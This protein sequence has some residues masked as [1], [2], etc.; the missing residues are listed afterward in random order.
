[1]DAKLAVITGADGGMGRIITTAVAKAG[2]QVIM[3][4]RN[5]ES[6]RQICEQI[7][8]D[9]HN[10]QIEVRG[11][12]LASL[13]SVST[14]AQTLLQEKRTLSLFINNAGVLTTSNRRSE[15]G[16]ETI[17][18][19]N[20]VAP[21]LLTRLLLP[22]MESGSR[23][24][25]TV[26]CTYM[27]GRIQDHFFEKGKDGRFNRISVYSN[28]KLALLLFTRE[29]AQ[30]VKEKGITV[31]ASD[32]GIVDTNMIRMDAWFDPLTDYLFRPFIKT[33]AQ[34][35]ATA[36]HLAL[37]EEARGKSACC[38]ANSKERK[39]SKRFTEH[40]AQTKLWQDTETLLRS[41]GFSL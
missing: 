6:A 32:P 35:A 36:I 2:Y 13:T 23:I 30:R 22:L 24:V 8:E 17:V 37:S 41:L 38:Y 33:P 40:P 16:L 28:T 1:M 20:Y 9:T 10:K 12:N 3:A 18:S 4:C 29:L 25:N 39:L 26:S 31:N 15:E 19:V 21:Y 11:I 5:V 27:I 14:F 34:G 7:K